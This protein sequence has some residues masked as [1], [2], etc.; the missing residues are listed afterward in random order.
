MRSIQVGLPVLAIAAGISL[1]AR[2]DPA[3]KVLL[4]WDDP[5]TTDLDGDGLVAHQEAILGT[6]DTTPDSDGDF[7]D[8]LVEFARGSN[9]LD[10]NSIP[11]VQAVSVGV[12]GRTDQGV[13]TLVSAI[14]ASDAQFPGFGFEM[15]ISWQGVVLPINTNL[16][17]SA[18]TITINASADPTGW[19]ILLETPI[20]E[21]MVQAT[22]YMGLYSVVTETNPADPLDPEIV[23][24][25]LNAFDID[26]DTA[27]LMASPPSVQGGTGSVYE[28]LGRGEDLPST[29]QPD[30]ICWQLT[31]QVGID[32]ASVT[33][34]VE[35]AA[36]QDLD[37]YC[38]TTSCQNSISTEVTV[39]DAGALAGGS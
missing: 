35:D 4:A 14:Y 2:E 16:V 37:S 1:L 3:E 27:A 11:T 18:S 32:G 23:A 20:P 29:W 28:P 21:S 13:L 7:V 6:L 39:L 24:G 15:G 8:D 38:H 33:L 17:L 10:A 31:N 19:I 30:K 26:G 34:S 9:P 36:C 5:M 22:G 25:V 12:S